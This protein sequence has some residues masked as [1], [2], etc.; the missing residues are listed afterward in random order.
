[1]RS[2]AFQWVAREYRISTFGFLPCADVTFYRH[3]AGA[4]P[5]ANFRF[6]LSPRVVDVFK[7]CLRKVPLGIVVGLIGSGLGSRGVIG[8]AAAGNWA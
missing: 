8:M 2:D 4:T 1:M 3:V 5:V 7:V 6:G